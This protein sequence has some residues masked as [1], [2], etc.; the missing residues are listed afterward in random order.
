[1]Q[2]PLLICRDCDLLMHQRA[3]PVGHSAQCPRCG[4]QL[5]N[6]VHNTFERTFALSL[7]GLIL[8]IPANIFPVL[9][10]NT[11]GFERQQTVLSSITALYDNQLYLVSLLVLFCALLIPLMKLVL[12]CYLSGSLLIRRRL[13]GQIWALRGYHQLDT[14][15]MLEIYLLGVIISIIKLVDIAK[16]SPGIGLYSLA[17]LILLT[18]ACSTQFDEGR[19]WRRLKQ[20]ERRA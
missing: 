1:V 17:A 15:S 2:Q 4:H 16:V 5:R 10:L 11:L 18:L 7:A 9:T 8:F 12:L 19:F 6:S 3:T 14:W 13:P 20:L